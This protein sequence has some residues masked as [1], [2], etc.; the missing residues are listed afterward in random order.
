MKTAKTIQKETAFV[1]ESRH[2]V[3]MSFSSYC[4]GLARVGMED[5]MNMK[6]FLTLIHW[7]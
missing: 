3:Q 4:Y 2:A 7:W 1:S 6:H 5:R